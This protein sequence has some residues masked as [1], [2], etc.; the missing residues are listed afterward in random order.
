MAKDVPNFVQPT[1]FFCFSYQVSADWF[2]SWSSLI[3]TLRTQTRCSLCQTKFGMLMTF[4]I[5][6]Q[7]I[8]KDKCQGIQQWHTKNI[9][10]SS[11]GVS[12]DFLVN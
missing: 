1:E 9:I 8:A 12:R 11:G 2:F 7:Y 5:Y 6:R 3:K 4:Q 10:H